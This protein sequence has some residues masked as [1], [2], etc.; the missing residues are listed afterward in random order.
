[1]SL[2]GKRLRSPKAAAVAG[3]LFAVLLISVLLLFRSSVPRDVLDDG[4]WLSARLERLMLAIN[5]MPFAGIAFL[6]FIGVVRDRMADTEDRLFA[7]VFLGSGLLFLAMM[8][9]AVALF[10]AMVAVQ[11]S[12]PGSLAN[13][14]TFALARALAYTIVNVYAIKMAGV[15]MLITSTIAVR[16]A[17]VAR[18]L[19]VPGFVM[20]LFLLFASQWVDWSFI[21]FP[22]WALLISV[23]ILIANLHRASVT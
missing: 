1:M 18:W 5:L 21:V 3:I 4:A 9:V 16:T 12:R 2:T 22:A 7:T 13:S 17:F 11:L 10:G 8:F 14:T 6:W 23:Y 20:A 19:A 15:F